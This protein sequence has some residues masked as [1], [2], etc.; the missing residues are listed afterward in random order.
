VYLKISA[1]P[2]DLTAQKLYEIAD[3]I[4]LILRINRSDLTIRILTGS[5][6][7]EITIYPGPAGANDGPALATSLKNKFLS[8]DLLSLGG[9]AIISASTD[10]ASITYSP[11]VTPT[12][13]PVLLGAPTRVPSST[14]T[15]TVPPTYVELTYPP[16]TTDPTI[17]PTPGIPR[18]SGQQTLRAYSG[19]ISDGSGLYAASM[20]CS[21]VIVSPSGAAIKLGFTEFGLE[22]NFD[23]VKVYD[24]P[25]AS[26][27]LLGSLTG[28]ARPAPLTATSGAMFVLFTT[29]FLGSEV[30]FTG[31]F[32]TGGSGSAGGFVPALPS[33]MISPA[34][35]IGFVNAPSG[36]SDAKVTKSPT[37][38]GAG[39]VCFGGIAWTTTL[40]W[41]QAVAVSDGPGR[42]A[43]NSDC[44]WTLKV[45]AGGRI[46]L[47][48]SM[49][50][51][52][53]GYDTL[54]VYDGPSTSSPK[55]AALSGSTIPGA[56][57]DSRCRFGW[58][59][60]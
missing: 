33:P 11:S 32:E 9:M 30:G 41:P 12:S 18:C 23:F 31:E 52:E 27:P 59:Q 20:A 48:F 57:V 51:L 14:R 36:S 15:P 58:H 55:L 3:Q 43:P 56:L 40:T 35:V 8:F 4:A 17:A 60:S 24:G 49:L 10:S 5:L 47:V 34:P 39:A 21:W 38:T 28:F 22:Q 29:D 7:L 46:R 50:N 42:Y 53:V 13:A 54:V 6:I 25:S 1:S 19:V 37:S 2:E 44:Q 16:T 45:P 26:S